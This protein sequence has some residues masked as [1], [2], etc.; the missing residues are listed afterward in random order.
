MNRTELVRIGL[1]ILAVLLGLGGLA[2]IGRATLYVFAIVLTAYMPPDAFSR[3]M[4]EQFQTA[5]LGCIA[6]L[7]AVFCLVVVGRLQNVSPTDSS[8]R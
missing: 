5:G 4:N 6:M 8:L 1:G 3:F 7:A 2:L